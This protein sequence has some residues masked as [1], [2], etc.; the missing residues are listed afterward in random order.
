MY[1]YGHV[2]QIKFRPQRRAKALLV[3]LA[4]ACVRFIVQRVQTKCACILYSQCTSRARHAYIMRPVPMPTYPPSPDDFARRQRRRTTKR[5]VLRST[6]LT[7]R[8]PP[9]VSVW[10]QLLAVCAHALLCVCVCVLSLNKHDMKCPHDERACC[11]CVCVALC[12]C[13][14]PAAGFDAD[15]FCAISARRFS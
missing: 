3:A 5:R 9:P 13:C 6:H 12:A 8:T 7:S 2:I 11:V 10:W 14:A 4:H 15:H 1:T